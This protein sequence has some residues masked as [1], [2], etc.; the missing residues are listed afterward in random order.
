MNT[1]TKIHDFPSFFS[2]L[3]NTKPFS[4]VFSVMSAILIWFAVSVTAYKTT[5]VTFY[6]IPVSEDISGTLAEANGLSAVSCDVE[7]VTVELEGNRFQIGR[8]KQEDLTAYLQLGNIS[9]NGEFNFEIAVRSDTNISFNTNK[10]TPAYATVKLDKIETRTFDV[11]ASF[12][13]LK[14]SSGHVLNK[15]DVTCEPSVVEITGPSAQLDEIAKVDVFSDKSVEIDSLYSLYTS[16][17]RLY[18]EE[19]ALMDMDSLEIPSTSFQVTIPVL[20]QKE[21]AL[22]YDIRNAFS[23]FDLNWLRERLHLSEESITLASQTNT[24]FADRD[25]YNVGFVTLDA[26][27]LDFSKEFD[28]ELKEDF[29]NQSGFQQ[30]TLT[31]DNE[32]LASREVWVT[33]DNISIINAPKD[34]DYQ[35]TTQKMLINIIGDK[36][37]LKNLSTQ[38]II[39]TV[40]LMN[41]NVQQSMTGSPDA[42]ISISPKN[43]DS[44]EDDL[45][46]MWAVGNY[47]VVVEFTEHVRETVSETASSMTED[48]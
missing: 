29:I 25:N 4:I 26:I 22:T 42:T 1:N 15:E 33:S 21:L 40:D 3:F 14:V 41:Y 9:T 11:S 45:V 36:E 34:Y 18:T 10:I 24:V 35:I 6:N 27:S 47:R 28:I 44:S 37:E 12:P 17:I 38:N 43:T 23:G 13:N 19:G 48:E 30:V 46:R 5:H 31:L 39:V 2:K 8:L 16:E 20:T 7:T 32:E